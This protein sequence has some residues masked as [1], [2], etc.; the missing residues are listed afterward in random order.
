MNISWYLKNGCETLLFLNQL[1]MIWTSSINKYFYMTDFDLQVQIKAINKFW[2][3]SLCYSVQINFWQKSLMTW[4]I[5]DQRR[6]VPW[7]DAKYQ[8]RD[9]SVSLYRNNVLKFNS[10]NRYQTV[11]QLHWMQFIVII[12]TTRLLIYDNTSWKIM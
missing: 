4:K 10:I 12:Y 7:T 11:H 2:K 5:A 6:R 3:K 1:V 9:C 8:L